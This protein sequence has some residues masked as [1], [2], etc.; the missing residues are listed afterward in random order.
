MNTCSGCVKFWVSV[1]EGFCDSIA[2]TRLNV[3]DVINSADRNCL[4]NRSDQPDS[5]AVLLIAV[6]DKKPTRVLLA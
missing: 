1:V 6:S 5:A 4:V 3:L 2:A